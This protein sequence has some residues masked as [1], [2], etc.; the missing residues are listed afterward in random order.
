M[1]GIPGTLVHLIE[2][3]YP[4]YKAALLES[5]C[6]SPSYFGVV[7]V[8]RILN[9]KLSAPE[10]AEYLQALNEVVSNGSAP[11][12]VRKTTERFLVRQHAINP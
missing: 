3:Y 4:S 7:M 1:E 12:V 10:R 5:L 9:S 6:R 2:R 8:N 11:L